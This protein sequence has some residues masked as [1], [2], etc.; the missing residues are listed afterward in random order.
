MGNQH[1][2]FCTVI[3]IGY[4]LGLRHP[5]EHTYKTIAAMM[6]A[7]LNTTAELNA[8]SPDVKNSTAPSVKGVW[9]KRV[10][11][12]KNDSGNILILPAL[13]QEYQSTWPAEFSAVYGIHTPEP[14]PGLLEIN[15][16]AMMVKCCGSATGTAAVATPAQPVDA[17]QMFSM[18]QQMMLVNQ[19]NLFRLDD[20]D[21]VQAPLRLS[22][23]DS[24]G[25]IA[26]SRLPRTS[27]C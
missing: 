22:R 17:R 20:I 5:S 19:Q 11:K 23:A 13:W 3:D 21:R 1:Q 7:T 14:C 4:S 12:C 26:R 16:Q 24:S 8:I 10:G 15:R 27:L 6:L 2:F 18:C 25:R 9:S